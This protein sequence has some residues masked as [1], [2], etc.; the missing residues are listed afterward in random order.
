VSVSTQLPLHSV[1]P[2]GQ[3]ITHSPLLH[4]SSS[5][6]ASLQPPQLSWSLSRSTQVPPQAVKPEG[7]L[8]VQTPSEQTSPALHALPQEPQLPGST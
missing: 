4:T 8:R 5:E 2:A 6:Q 3:E 7:Q 1:S